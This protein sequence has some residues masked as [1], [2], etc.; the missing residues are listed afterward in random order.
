MSLIFNSL[1]LSYKFPTPHPFDEKEF[2]EN[3]EDTFIQSTVPGVDMA[4]PDKTNSVYYIKSGNCELNFQPD[5]GI[6]GVKGNNFSEV[7]TIFNDINN[8][9]S[10][11]MEININEVD[12]LELISDGRF[13][14]KELPLVTISKN[15]TFKKASII[16]DFFNNEEI[17]P[18]EI[19]YCPK[20]SV[21]NKRNIRELNDWFEL[22]IMPLIV[23][24]S[25]YYWQVIF[26]NDDVSKVKLFWNDIE[27]KI[28]EL[29][30]R[31]EG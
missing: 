1:G 19:R 27:S 14:G 30:V 15:H 31:L 23:N 29:F 28:N 4:E 11:K 2:L 13:K 7:D 3:L 8:I 6:V 5:R 16:Q 25:F 20:E 10:D 17:I 22:Q 26:R 12:Y 21:N 18:F 9:L 24:P